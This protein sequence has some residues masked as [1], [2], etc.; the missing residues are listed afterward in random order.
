MDI[1]GKGIV[2]VTGIGE[3][4]GSKTVQFVIVPKFL[5]WLLL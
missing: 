1:V 4:G 5:K 2:T 3:Y